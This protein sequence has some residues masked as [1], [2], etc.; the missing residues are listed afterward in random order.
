V[1]SGLNIGQ[2]EMVIGVKCGGDE[3]KDMT[4]IIYG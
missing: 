3:N 1:G 2:Q 4:N